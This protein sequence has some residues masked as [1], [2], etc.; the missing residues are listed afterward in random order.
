MLEVWRVAGAQTG[1]A[2][3]AKSITSEVIS[4]TGEKLDWHPRCEYLAHSGG[5]RASVFTS[6]LDPIW[7]TKT[8]YPS[9]VRFSDDGKML[10]VGDWS[11]GAI[12]SWPAA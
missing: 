12:H 2:S 8:T 7:S 6:T 9:D 4:G 11:K 5:E 1:A 10:A 3:L